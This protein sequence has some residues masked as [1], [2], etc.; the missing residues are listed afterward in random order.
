MPRALSVLVVVLLLA[1]VAFLPQADPHRLAVQAASGLLAEPGRAPV[2]GEDPG[3]TP[4]DVLLA[5][6]AFRADAEPGDPRP[7][8][9]EAPRP[10]GGRLALYG[11]RYETRGLGAEI[12]AE[13]LTAETET[14]ALLIH[15]EL[16]DALVRG[17]RTWAGE[18]DLALVIE[19]AEWPRAGGAS[20]RLLSEPGTLELEVLTPEGARRRFLHDWDPPSPSSVWPPIVAIAL[21]LALRRPVVALFAGVLM[22][23]YL[24]RVGGGA[25]PVPSVVG[26]LGDVFTV[27]FWGQFRDGDRLRIIGFVVAMLAMVGVV[28]RNGGLH[29]VMDHV[30]RLAKSARRTQVATWLMGL[31][32]FFDDYA[33]TI[34]VGSTMRPLSDRFRVAREKL[35]YIVDSTAAPVAGISLFSTWIA[36]EVSTFSAQLP[37]AG[38]T[39]SQ[40]YEV[41]IQ[42]LPYRFY[43]LLTLFFVGL[44]VISGRDFGPMLKAERRARET[45]QLVREGAKPMVGERAT[46][47]RAAPGITPRAYRAVVPLTA[48]IAVTLL[49]MVHSGWGPSGGSASFQQ[50]GFVKGLS[51]L[52][53]KS[54]SYGALLYGSTTGLVLGVLFSL[55]AGMRAEILRAA[56]NTLRSMGIAILI[57]YLAWMIGA[58]SAELGTAEYL[59]V[60]LRGVLHPLLLPLILFALAGAVSFATGSS[61]GTMSILLP[62][63]V[64]LAFGLGGQTELGGLALMVI[65]IGAVLEGSIFGDHCS[66][67]S[68]TTVLSSVATASDH[69]DHVRT[70]VPYAV[71]TM[72]VAMV[73]CYLPCT[74]LG[75]SPFL[76]LGIGAAVLWVALW[77][78][79][80]RVQAKG[81]AAP[82]APAPDP[83]PQGAGRA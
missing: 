48:F 69:V 78:L 35:A 56:W 39:P 36:F 29:G 58:A 30:A 1:L 49:W 82:A 81:A 42:T 17:L 54:D 28:T 64:G 60:A 24:L 40:G 27:F 4:I 13:D 12:A 43:C 75:W 20:L 77:V 67:L 10:A 71:L 74:A 80:E 26:G 34:L 6:R 8:E 65:S 38:L 21:A 62:L 68:D 61:W 25:G 44:V 31:L 70:Q 79:G 2:E 59:T 14:D 73:A 32:V 3:L 33:N 57:L 7:G 83:L 22:A 18:Q 53:G 19:G 15:G 5:S 45:G 23:A 41:F 63:V 16:R 52:L 50:H 47:M 9:A 46:A 55:L 11:V 37:A 51:L 66:P 72:V 76:G